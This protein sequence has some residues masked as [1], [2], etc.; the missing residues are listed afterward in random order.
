M[1]KDDFMDLYNTYHIK[2]LCFMLGCSAPTIYKRIKELGI[3]KK[4]QGKGKRTR[5]KLV[6]ED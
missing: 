1:R 5:N 3:P 2:E 6:I 4:G